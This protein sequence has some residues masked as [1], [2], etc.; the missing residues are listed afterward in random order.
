MK[1]MHLI[2][3]C[4]LGVAF[5]MTGR[6]QPSQVMMEQL[7]YQPAPEE[8]V[9]KR[10]ASRDLRLFRFSAVKASSE[11]PRPAVIWIH[12]GG[13]KGG[14]Y[15]SFYPLAR[16]TAERGA[17]SF[18]VEYRLVEDGK[19]SVGDCV[20]D[21]KS[22]VRYLRR[23]AEALGIDPERIAVVGESAG[24]HLAACVGTLDGFNDPADDLNVSSRPNALVLYN[25]L[26]RF[27]GSRFAKFFTDVVSEQE[28]DRAMRE[29]SPLLYVR[30]GLA[31]TLC[32]H[33]LADTVVLPDD[34]R[35]FAIAMEQVGNR[36][37][38]VLL[39]DTPHAFLVPNYKSSESDVVRTLRLADEFLISIGY[40]SGSPTLVVSDPPAWIGKNE[41]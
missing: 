7:L 2:V 14:T 6:S 41:R 21:C 8:I 37:D 10:L 4:L 36:C 19:T 29:L 13:W 9:Y 33:G 3:L 25:P 40:F 26:T 27:E 34:S 11:E 17:E 24:G 22:A 12:G 30:S 38:L 35:L 31:P 20:A 18:V 5:A 16:Y 32:V 15:E 1:Q 39:P 28:A 23:N